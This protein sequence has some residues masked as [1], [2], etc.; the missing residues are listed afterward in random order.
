MCCRTATYHVTLDQIKSAGY[1]RDSMKLFEH[2]FPFH[3]DYT[4]EWDL[5]VFKLIIDAY[6]KRN[7]T[8]QSDAL[9][10][11]T[12]LLNRISSVKK[13]EFSFGHPKVD[14][15][16]SLL[17]VPGSGALIK[18]RKGF[19]T[20][21]WAGWQGEVTI[22]YWL[23][24]IQNRDGQHADDV[25]ELRV[26]DTDD[27]GLHFVRETD[28]AIVLPGLASLEAYG[29]GVYSSVTMLQVKRV[30]AQGEMY[31]RYHDG[32][33]ERADADLWCVFDK[34]G[35]AVPHCDLSQLSTLRLLLST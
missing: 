18:R 32:T 20:W 15:V 30:A 14:F 11:I 23:K 2:K 21:S 10:A 6:T 4:Q 22:P 35:Q 19:P 25:F 3:L 26:D 8:C 17:W 5:G 34:D 29:L 12:G 1:G 24:S 28:V 7:L 31:D 33:T 13:I 9:A 16:R 27:D